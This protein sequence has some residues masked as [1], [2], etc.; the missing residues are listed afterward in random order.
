MYFVGKEAGSSVYRPVRVNRYGA[1]QDWP[2]GFF[3]E[4]QREAEEIIRAAIAKKREER[5]GNDA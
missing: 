5:R 4:S 1:I 2:D 3:D